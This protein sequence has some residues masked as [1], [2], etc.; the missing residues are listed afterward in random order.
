MQLSGMGR[1]ILKMA[2]KIGVVK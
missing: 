2:K 1:G